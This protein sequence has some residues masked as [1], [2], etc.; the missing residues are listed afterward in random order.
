[1]IECYVLRVLCTRA[2][3]NR[4][5]GCAR[6]QA[7]SHPGTSPT[8]RSDIVL[9]V[10]D[11]REVPRRRSLPCAAVPYVQYR[12]IEKQGVVLVQQIYYCSY[13]PCQR[14]LVPWDWNR[15]SLVWESRVG[16]LL[17]SYSCYLALLFRQESK[18]QK[19]LSLSI[20]ILVTRIRSA[21]EVSKW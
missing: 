9:N 16:L 3:N 12:K 15:D 14:F 19:K 17:S 8:R 18:G 11:M 4:C 7:P 13:I 10:H 6:W 21:A 2:V 20:W 1:M 5:D